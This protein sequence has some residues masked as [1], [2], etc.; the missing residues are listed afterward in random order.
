MQPTQNIEDQT[1]DHCESSRGSFAPHPY[2]VPPGEQL[3]LEVG[4]ICHKQFAQ[5]PQCFT[6]K[7]TQKRSSEVWKDVHGKFPRTCDES[8][9]GTAACCGV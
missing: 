9:G 1:T 6:S 4:K 8:T 2:V 3:S 7:V 5:T